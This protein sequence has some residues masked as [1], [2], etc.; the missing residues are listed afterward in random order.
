MAGATREQALSLIAAA[1]NHG[2]LAVKLSSLKQAREILL[3][4]EPS[5]AA[6]L[7][8][9]LAE[10]QSS[11]EVLV[12]QFLAE[13]RARG[14]S[15]HTLLKTE[16]EKMFIEE[17]CLNAVEQSSVLMPT[18]LTL[19]KDNA[20]IVV[21]Q[22]IISG[23]TFFCGS[24]REIGLQFLRTG[25]VERWHEELWRWMVKFK[26]AMYGIAVQPGP[27]QTKLLAVKFLEICILLFS[28]DA[29]DSE[30]YVKEGKVR[31]FN[32]S[33]VV[34][35][36][37]ILD[38]TSLTLEANKSL[39][40]LLDLLQLTNTLSGSLIISVINRV[41]HALSLSRDWRLVL[42]IEVF[43]A[44]LL[45]LFVSL[46]ALARRR[47][48]HYSTILSSLLSFDPNFE[49]LRGHAASI[50]YS[51]R[52]AFLG[53][54]RC[55]HPA[56][57]E[58]RET[59]L[60]ALRAMN[61]GDAADQV[62]R[63]VD[64]IIKNAERSVRDARYGKED[65]LSNLPSISG[66]LNKK[67]SMLW[68]AEGPT[69]TGEMPLK[70]PYYGHVGNTVM[71][72]KMPGD[73]VQDDISTNGVTSNVSLLEIDLTPVEQM[74][75]MIGALLAEG[76]RGAESLEILISK[77]QPDLLA[78]IVIANMKH[79][80]KSPPPLASRIGNITINTQMP[81]S[82]ALPQPTVPTAPTVSVQPS[83]LTSEV[84][85]SFSPV[86]ISTASDFISV[87]NAPLEFKRDPRR[88]PRRLDPRRASVSAGSQTLPA[89]EEIVDVQSGLDSA[90]SLSGPFSLSEKK[91]SEKLVI[92]KTK[93][94]LEVSEVSVVQ[95]PDHLMPKENEGITDE[96][97]EPGKDLEVHMASDVA[98]S[99]V[100]SVEQEMMSQSTSDLMLMERS[101]AEV[102][103]PDQH[104]PVISST[105]ASDDSSQDLPVIPSFVELTEEQKVKVS[106]MAVERIFES[107]K[108]LQSGCS[109][110]RM[111][112]LGRLIAQ[113]DADDTVAILQKHLISDCRLQ[114]GHELAMHVLYYLYSMMVSASEESC[115]SAAN[116]YER[117]LLSMARSFQDK[118]PASDKSLSRFLG[119]VPLLTDSSL[120][121]L[122]DLC[123]ANGIKHSDIDA[124]EGDRVTQGLGAVWNLIL[125]RP[126][127]RKA[128]LEI[129]LRCA[130]HVQDDVR[131]KA[132][133]LV[134]NKLYPLSY[135]TEN[136][137]RFAT[138]M[139]LSV[140]DQIPDKEISQAGAAERVAEDNILILQRRLPDYPESNAGLDFL[141]D[142]GQE[143]SV[144]GSQ[145][146][147][148]GAS[149]SDSAKGTQQVVP[150][151]SNVSLSHAQR[152]TS[153]FFALCTKKPSLL[154]VVFD[155]YGQAPKII[156]QAIHRHV[157]I[158]MKNLRASY[159]QLLP[160]ISNPPQG[161]ENLLMLVLQI[162]TEETVPSTDLI[163]SVKHLYETK[164]KD[165]AILIPILSLLSKDEVLPIFARLVDLPLEKFQI[166]LARILQVSEAKLEDNMKNAKLRSCRRGAIGDEDGET[167]IR[168]VC[169]MNSKDRSAPLFSLSNLDLSLRFVASDLISAVS[170]HISCPVRVGSCRHGYSSSKCRVQITDACSACFEQRT[171][172][173]Q[174]VLAKALNHLV[175][176][177]M[178]ILSKLVSKQIWKMPKLWVG[179]LKCASQTQPHS[180]RVLLQLP[181]Q[182]LESALNKYSNLRGPLAVHASQP[183]IRSSL[184][185]SLLVVLGL[186]NESQ[187]QQRSFLPSALH[188]SD[189]SSSVHGATLT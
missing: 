117:F 163:A 160:I 77:I 73:S 177:V 48:Q 152:C 69:S 56:M 30:I 151:V 109:Q 183:S 59:L 141:I 157:P 123:C 82:N 83:A 88:D 50:Q 140:V 86:A 10:L 174:Q 146:S 118:L 176:F 76:E 122:E 178:E 106:K 172:F 145:N 70:R 110:T 62:I 91:N 45:N 166:A 55:T 14:I 35:G 168:I 89:N 2:D 164:L 72:T 3:S 18:I 124:H 29:N 52:T 189:A 38:P 19:L 53:F 93:T 46:A 47:P 100:D 119:E 97:T 173:T 104:S 186:A 68:E 181:P 129:A 133:R 95:S 96:A 182:Q 165:A 103:E 188:T 9:Y 137:E 101:D 108:H 54:L 41:P 58:S 184:P 120:K 131:A 139:L 81:S 128:C 132:I 74:I 102:L 105:C 149:E 171:V 84:V 127:D 8:P 75:A 44:V 39:H 17:L 1:M 111:A 114:K 125:G 144:S 134:A 142:G 36:H 31:N 22:A 79:L 107:C 7:F 15:M 116:I 99:L 49:T 121:L 187:T 156:K 138:N 158:L 135:V 43:K 67:R 42:S 21:R 130:V 65:Q 98:F 92:A 87:T 60:R 180:F 113:N 24:L 57:M 33:W 23:S 32:I 136:I 25:R 179:F 51:L 6:E 153:L 162:L 169:E 28:S 37:P 80:P 155:V 159:S 126:H 26:D 167:R 4:V 150:N 115:S 5:F 185:R 78:D 154:Q 175:D 63:K 161:S 20:L 12:R 27:T 148:P 147:E 61:A 71:P 34:G 85:P 13:I 40:I 112:L 16:R 143:T 64:K 11:P 170:T 94:E 90:N 66:D